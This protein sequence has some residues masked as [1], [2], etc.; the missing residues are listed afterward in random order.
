[1]LLRLA[2]RNTRRHRVRTALTAG[3]VVIGVSLLV[4]GLAWVQGIFG[5]ALTQATAASGHVRVVTREYAAHEEL[6]PL[7]ANLPD[8]GAV[9]PLVKRQRGVIA[10]E[11]RI[12]AGVTVTVGEELG[13][14][15][16]LAVGASDAWFRERLEAPAHVV[17]G[18]WMTGAGELCMGARVAEDAKVSLGDEVVLVGMTQDGSLSPIKGKLVC[19]VRLGGLLDHQVLVPLERMQW[20]TDIPGGATELLVY[21]SRYED[22]RALARSLREVPALSGY[23]IQAW[24]EREPLASLMGT[25]TGVRF[26]VI[27][28]VVLLA[29]LGIWN[30]M[31]TS[32]LERTREIGVLRALGLTRAGAVSLFVIEALAIAVGGGIAGVGLGLV[33]AL[34]LERYGI[35]IGAETTGRLALPISEVVHAQVSPGILL[36][37]FTLGLAMALLGSVPAALRAASVQP[38]AAMRTGR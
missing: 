21:G 11:P 12:S 6:Q 19:I 30:T 36:G 18:R 13:D 23:A 8:A 26:F 4:V 16:A 34:V 3:M 15:F 24:D 29:A 37:A 10:V 9:L 38:V 25:I 7:Y 1:M 20:L 27:L 22:G 2:A 31:T 5:Q 17:R 32:V 14:V 35:R 33:P 28:A